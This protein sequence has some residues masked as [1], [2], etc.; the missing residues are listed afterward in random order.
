ML[1]EIFYN[2]IAHSKGIY[3]TLECGIKLGL[4]GKKKKKKKKKKKV[5]GPDRPMFKAY[6]YQFLAGWSWPNHLVYSLKFLFCEGE[7]YCRL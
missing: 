2:K 3:M 1:R 6:V 7:V 4:C 5:L